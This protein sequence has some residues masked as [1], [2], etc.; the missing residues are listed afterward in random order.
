[1]VNLSYDLSRGMFIEGSIPAIKIERGSHVVFD[2]HMRMEGD[3]AV[4]RKSLHTGAYRVTSYQ[5]PCDGNC[6]NL[7]RPTDSCSLWVTI[8]PG[9][10]LVLDVIERPSLG[11]TFEPRAT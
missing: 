10:E 5:L 7:D 1:M 11:C 4:L 3:G 9:S 6:G 2:G 8:N